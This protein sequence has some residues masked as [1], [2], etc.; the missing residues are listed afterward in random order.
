MFAL[1]PLHLCRYPTTPHIAARMLFTIDSVY[2]DIE[3]KHVGDFGCGGG[4]LG[5]GCAILGAGSVV[6]IDVDQKSLDLARQNA[7]EMDLKEETDFVLADIAALAAHDAG[8]RWGAA[9]RAATGPAVK[10]MSEPQPEPELQLQ[11][12]T[13]PLE[14]FLR[15]A[16]D[17]VVEEQPTDPMAAMAALCRAR[18]AAYSTME[19][20]EYARYQREGAYHVS[21][22]NQQQCHSPSAHVSTV[23]T[24]LRIYNSGQPHSRSV[25][26]PRAC[27]KKAAVARPRL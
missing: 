1:C 24:H 12:G 8:Q 11:P 20:A 21:V 25:V 14:S 16:L 7:V 2:D 9:A 26:Q 27:V 10:S 13:H 18:A 22:Q 17:R 19:Q 5:F 4:T 15:S 6:G 3:D 23:P